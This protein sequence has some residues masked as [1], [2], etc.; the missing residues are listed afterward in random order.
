MKKLIIIAAV[1]VVSA[2][3]AF[4][5]DAQSVTYLSGVNGGTNNIAATSTNNLST[6]QTA[7]IYSR[8]IS[9]QPSFALT[10]T[11][12]SACTFAIS[13]S[14]DNANWNLYG[15]LSVTAAGTTPVNIVTNI[16]TGGTVFW[17]LGPVGNPN[18]NAMTNVAVAIGKR[19]GL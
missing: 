19:N 9:L 4:N 8:W 18:A 7:V 12:T 1:A 10:S 2:I 3:S 11:G 17:K 15:T 14:V 5:A 6:S 13:N 16:D